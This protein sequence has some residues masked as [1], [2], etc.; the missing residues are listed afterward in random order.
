ME[1]TAKYLI[2][3]EL[4]ANGVIERSDVVGAIFGQTEGLL[5]EELDLRVLQRTS[6][7]GRID[8]EV[9]SEGGTSFGRVTIA[10]GLDQV[11]TAVLAAALE[12]LNRVGPCR[13]DLDI[14][15]IEDVRAAKR[16]QVI[17]RA[18]ELLGT[19]FDDATMSTDE[20][21]E[22][23]RRNVRVADVTDYEGFPAGP[24]VADGDAVIVVEGRSDVVTLLRYGIKNAVAVEGTNVPDEVAEL[25]RNRTT[26]AFLD[27][28][29]GGELILKELAQVGNVD[30]V[31]FA[32]TGRSVE[33]LTRPE[34]T[35]AL[36]DKV[37]FDRLA[38]ASVSHT[39][40][41]PAASPTIDEQTD[42]AT[43]DE[44]TDS[45]AIDER[46]DMR[47]ADE[48]IGSQATESASTG[49]DDGTIPEL[50]AQTESDN[51]T[52]QSESSQETAG[53]S[54]GDTV[55][56][57]EPDESHEPATL[58]GHVRAVIDGERGT[59]RSLDKTY[60]II[61]E[62]PAEGSFDVISEAES[63]PHAVVVDGAV[64]QRLLDVAAQRGVE[65]LVGRSAGE[66]TK[67]PTSVR[68]LTAADLAAEP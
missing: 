15:E 2:H 50:I 6:K 66:F 1:D 35:A 46:G 44:Q 23:V 31:A 16:T 7:L 5:G 42:S 29:R 28:D 68:V 36:R 8:V 48:S 49:D 55:T 4:R 40:D 27:G 14:I 38:D 18:T 65:Y 21:I 43:V 37:R 67:Q 61:S 30:Y 10:S 13:A 26:T 57:L 58:R 17:D 56:D 41:D 20:L 25:T 19:A 51:A 39:V 63:V 22:T 64:S 34:A 54:T 33:D 47:T 3:A 45:A 52:A 60:E 12:T 53:A 9:E 59:A 32:P 11:E 24:R 62:E